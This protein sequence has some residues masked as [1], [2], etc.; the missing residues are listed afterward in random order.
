MNLKKDADTAYH[1]IDKL[2]GA[3]NYLNWCRND[4]AVLIRNNRTLLGL[5]AF[6]ESA[7]NVEM[8]K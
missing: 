3:G 4:R 2:K 5:I 7:T 1:K 8:K 6:P